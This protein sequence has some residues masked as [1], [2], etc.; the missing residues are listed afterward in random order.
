MFT[1]L[2][3]AMTEHIF[4]C[5]AL[6]ILFAVCLATM[7]MTGIVVFAVIIVLFP[8]SWYIS[9]A[10]DYA[11]WANVNPVVCEKIARGEMPRDQFRE[12]IYPLAKNAQEAEWTLEA[13]KEV[14]GAL[15]KYCELMANLMKI[16]YQRQAE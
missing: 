5:L 9:G 13:E 11:V 3:W 8:A 14:R 16:P 7:K 6:L 1:F 15:D 10:M 12:K 2:W 4:V